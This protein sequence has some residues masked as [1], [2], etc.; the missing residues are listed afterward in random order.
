MTIVDAVII[1]IATAAVSAW[2]RNEARDH[3]SQ[4]ALGEDL[5]FRYGPRL[6][7]MSILVGVVAP[8]GVLWLALHFGFKEPGDPYYFA[9]ILAFFVIGGGWMLLE[10]VRTRVVIS[11]SGIRCTTGFRKAVTISWAEVQSVSYNPL[12]AWLTIQTVSGSRVHIGR[13][14][15]GAR[16]LAEALRQRLPTAVHRGALRYL[17]NS[18]AA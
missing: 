11:P 4:S 3:T 9:A 12:C 14:L 2:L 16:Q 17:A 6:T 8:V 7:A 5:E 10:A 13:Y 15:K 18:D 1:V